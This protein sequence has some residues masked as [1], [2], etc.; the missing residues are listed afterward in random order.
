MQI[1]PLSA[2]CGG[3]LPRWMSHV[4]H[5]RLRTPKYEKTTHVLQAP[6]GDQEYAEQEAGQLSTAMKLLLDA[7]NTMGDVHVAFTVLRSYFGACCVVYT[8]RVGL[9]T[10]AMIAADVFDSKIEETLRRMLG[11]A[12]PLDTFRDLQVP[13]SEE[14]P[15]FELGYSLPSHWRLLHI[16]FRSRS[17]ILS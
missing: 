2:P 14:T 17:T 6:I 1:K 4:I 16:S 8:Q 7:L 3:Q 10:L 11:V 5:I 15:T 9:P 12:L 13:I